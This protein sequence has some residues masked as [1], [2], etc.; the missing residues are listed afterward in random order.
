M[1]ELKSYEFLI[2]SAFDRV[3]S[4]KFYDINYKPYTKNFLQKIVKF[5]EKNERYEDCF[6]LSSFIEKRFDHNV[7]YI[8]INMKDYVKELEKI[9]NFP[10][11]FLNELNL[12]LT[13]CNLSS[14]DRIK[15]VEI[16]S[17]LEK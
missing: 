15:L 10:K 9:S 14:D 1:I 17:K 11:G 16:I 3:V 6:L 12:F 4:G 13:N 2:L 7:N 5:L 8:N